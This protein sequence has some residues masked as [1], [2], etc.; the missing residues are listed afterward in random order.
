MFLLSGAVLTII[1]RRQSAPTFEAV[2]DS[3]MLFNYQDL[4]NATKN[5]LLK[6]GEGGFGSVFRGTLPNS[7]AIILQ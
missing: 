6:L 5:F 2:D 7:T 4:K 3:L 1:W